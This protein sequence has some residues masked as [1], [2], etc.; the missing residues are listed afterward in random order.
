MRNNMLNWLLA[1]ALAIAVLACG[2]AVF[3]ASQCV[4]DVPGCVNKA[5]SLIL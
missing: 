1:L 5:G 3:G 2:F 4:S